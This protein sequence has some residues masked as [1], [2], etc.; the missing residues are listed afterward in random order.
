MRAA[1]WRYL[2]GMTLTDAP[3]VETRAEPPGEI[4]EVATATAETQATAP[5][6]A[7]FTLAQYH[8]AI[9]AGV[10][11][12][13]SKVEL[14]DERLIEIVSKGKRHDDIVNQLNVFFMSRFM[15][16]HICRVQSAVT[17]PPGSEPEPDYAIVDKES[18]RGR[19]HHP[20]P[21]DILLVIEVADS[22]LEYDRDTKAPIYAA[23]NLPEYWIVNV[24]H[25]PPELYTEPDPATGRYRT[26]RT[27]DAGDTFESPFCGEVAVA[28]LMG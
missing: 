20:E 3:R 11:T 22:S 5:R 19:T 13:Y 4:A 1:A 14:I 12:E 10:L 2:S 8:A 18:Y 17:L 24:R 9:E 15:Q 25:A 7:R 23:A 27:F 28:E 26:V 21:A 16:T 6:P